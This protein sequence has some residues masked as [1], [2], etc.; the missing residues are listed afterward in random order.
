MPIPPRA[1]PAG[2]VAW[3]SGDAA[4]WVRARPLWSVPAL[5]GAVGWAIGVEPLP[6]CGDVAP[7]G[8]DR[9]GTAQAGPAVG[10]LIRLATA[11]DLVLVAAPVLGVVLAPTELPGVD[12]SGT[13]AN[14]AVIGALGFGWAAALRRVTARRRQRELAERAA[15]EARHPVPRSLRPLRR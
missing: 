6:V 7:C 5:L 3:S 9:A 12:A 15:G 10:L 11:S 14:L 2:A 4:E 8:P 13:A 1:V